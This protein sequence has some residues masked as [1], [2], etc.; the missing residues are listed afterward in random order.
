MLTN[1]KFS[2]DI[3]TNYNIIHTDIANIVDLEL[4]YRTTRNDNM[5]RIQIRR[6]RERQLIL[7]SESVLEELLAARRRGKTAEFFCNRPRC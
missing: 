4:H 2:N 3:D 1:E 6:D 7:D 5:S